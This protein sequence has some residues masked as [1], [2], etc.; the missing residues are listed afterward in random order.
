MGEPKASWKY[1][2]TR[3]ILTQTNSILAKFRPSFFDLEF[4]VVPRLGIR[5]G[6]RKASLLWEVLSYRL[7]QYNIGTNGLVPVRYR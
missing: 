7:L 6:L 5:G 4:R 1:S 3:V 2:H